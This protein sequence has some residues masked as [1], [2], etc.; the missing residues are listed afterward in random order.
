MLKAAAKQIAAFLL[1]IS[2]LSHAATA[3]PRDPR[4]AVQEIA[5]LN[6]DLIH[7]M[8]LLRMSED[9]AFW[10][11]VSVLGAQNDWEFS[12]SG[13]VNYAWSLRLYETLGASDRE[14]ILVSQAISR[15]TVL[16]E[17]ERQAF[18][19]LFRKY[20]T[21]RGLGE[22]MHALLADNNVQD[23]LVLYEAEVLQ[24]RRDI[25]IAAASSSISIRDRIKEIELDVLLGR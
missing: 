15:S 11:S 4:Q 23:A 5:A 7:I 10:Q 18:D 20:E 17:Q 16:T 3:E 1:G 9:I 25:A 22:D 6:A 8:S 21:M 2:L 19:A 13:G 14:G 12:Y 24:L